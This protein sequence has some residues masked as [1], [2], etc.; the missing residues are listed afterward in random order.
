[1]KIV[2]VVEPFS[3]GITTFIIHLVNGMPQFENVVV[4]GSRVGADDL[5]RVRSKFNGSTRFTQWKNASRSINPWKDIRA[6]FQLYSILK[7]EKPDIIHLHSSKAGFIGRAIGLFVRSKIIYTPNGLA[8]ERKDVSS[9]YQKFYILLEWIASKMT[10]KVICCS[11][12]EH[13]VMTN[14]GIECDYINNGTII[15]YVT[16]KSHKIKKNTITVGCLALITEQ[17]DPRTFNKIARHFLANSKIKFIWIGDGHLR[18][19]LSS[20][21]IEVTGWLDTSNKDNKFSG[22]DIYLSCSLWEGLPFSVLEAMNNHQCLLL[23]KCVGNV[24][25]VDD[26]VNGHLFENSKDAIQKLEMLISDQEKILE[27]GEASFGILKKN[28]DVGRM[29]QEYQKI[30]MEAYESK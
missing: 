28:F 3:S 1:M 15:S 6:T 12:S 5:E 18:G 9:L 25:L 10:G 13:D 21:N 24:D 11:K 20:K 27:M 16:D 4:H 30:Y 2:H 19:Q 14:V 29:I 7:K 8:F 26:S 23:R 17:K 22:I